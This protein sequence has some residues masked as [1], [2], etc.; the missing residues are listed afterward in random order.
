[1]PKLQKIERKD[2]SEVYSV[3]IPLELIENLSWQKGDE[4]VANVDSHKLIISKV[5]KEEIKIEDGPS[6]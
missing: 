2:K 1:M 4:L 6:I 3:N 5:E